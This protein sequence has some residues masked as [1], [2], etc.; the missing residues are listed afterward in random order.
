M[1]GVYQSI[2]VTAAMFFTGQASNP[3]AAQ[4][5]RAMFHYPVTW[6]LWFVA[7]IVPGL[8]SLLIVPLIVYRMDPP[9]I[10][11]TPSIGIHSTRSE[12]VLVGSST[13]TTV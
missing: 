11:K 3:L 7:G 12:G 5:A 4:M 10:R 13:P 6:S 2:C 8:C 9:D 1:I